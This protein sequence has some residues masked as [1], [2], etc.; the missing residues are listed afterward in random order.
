VTF[1]LKASC[2]KLDTRREIAALAVG[3]SIAAH[4]LIGV[5]LAALWVPPGALAEGRRR[6]LVATDVDVLDEPG[7]DESIV[8]VSDDPDETLAQGERGASA[9]AEEV[10]APSEP[11]KAVE[12]AAKPMPAAARAPVPARDDAPRTSAKPLAP[13]V[14]LATG[15]ASAA[16]SGLP[17]GDADGGGGQKRP[18]L[19][20]LMARF[21]H[22]LAEFGSGVSAWQ[23]APAGDAGSITVTLAVDDEGKIDR[24]HDPFGGE[25]AKLPSLLVES[26]KRTNR[27]LVRKMGSKNVVVKFKVGAI[28][29][30]IVAP[31]G[32]TLKLS[33][34]SYDAKT[35]RGGSTF[36]LGSG[37]QVTFSVEVLGTTPLTPT[38]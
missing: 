6:E 22:D 33:F 11:P 20:S 3:L 9:P 12:P 25:A 27:A 24:N 37:R 29:S 1:D 13:A 14:S 32:D 17:V 35:R 38:P 31:A 15:S 34:D 7:S 2:N 23:N 18:E 21:T 10:A 19:P 30:D 16:A 28:V 5:A 36:V 26:V 4:V 8:D